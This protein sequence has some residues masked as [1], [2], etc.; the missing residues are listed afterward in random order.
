MDYFDT[1]VD[2]GM[3]YDFANAFDG[4]VKI[5]QFKRINNTTISWTEHPRLGNSRTPNIFIKL[6]FDKE[7]VPF[8]ELLVKFSD[9]IV[10]FQKFITA[11]DAIDYVNSAI[12]SVR[13]RKQRRDEIWSRYG[14]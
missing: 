9:Y 5:E 3:F 14:F 11:N 4:K 6:I 7:N 10:C 2:N 8:F 13:A 1:L 12:N